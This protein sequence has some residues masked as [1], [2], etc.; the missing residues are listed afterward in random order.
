MADI[1]VVFQKKAPTLVL[2]DPEAVMQQETILWRFHTADTPVKRVRISFANRHA[3]F[4]EVNG[5]KKSWIE[6]SVENRHAI[7]GQAPRYFRATDPTG[8]RVD[9]Y[10]IK[11][12]GSKGKLL[13]WATLDPT[14]RTDGP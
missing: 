6:K 2:E 8:S 13:K 14:I 9:K 1:H 11:A 10:T 7:W 3:T 4:F 12:Y 5:K